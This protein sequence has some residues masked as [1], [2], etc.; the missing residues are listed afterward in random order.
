MPARRSFLSASP[1]AAALHLHTRFLLLPLPERLLVV[2]LT[3]EVTSHGRQISV[4]QTQ[5]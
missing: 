4:P 5:A 1:E 3:T 2:S